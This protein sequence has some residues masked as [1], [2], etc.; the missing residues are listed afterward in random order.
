MADR[1]V[2][3]VLTAAV[4]GFTSAIGKAQSQV[5]TL[6]SSM[7]KASQTQSWSHV[8]TGLLAVGAT[9]TTIAGK[10]VS[11]AA[12]FDEAMSAVAATGDDAR[13]NIGQLRDLA[14]DM[15][16]RTKYSATEAAT[17]IEI[18]AKAGMSTADIISGGLSGALNLAASDNMS[19]EA[20]AEATA[21]TLTQF[22][23]AG[24]DAGHV[25]DLLAAGAGKAMG[26]VQDL[27]DALK[28][29]GLVA[30]NMGMSLEETVGTLSL[31]AQNG[32]VGA[33]AGT[34][35]KVMLQKLQNPSSTAKKAMD[36]LGIS[37]YD[38]SGKFIGM[39]S[40]AQQLQDKTAGLSQAQRDQAM[41]QIFGSHAIS[42]ATVLYKAGAQGVH[43]WTSAVNDQGFAEQMAAEKMNNLKGDLEQLSGAWETFMISAGSSAQGPLRA[44]MRGLTSI[45]DKL[46]E[47][48]QV[49][50]A[51]IMV[52]G[53]LGVSMV[54][55]GT[56]MKTVT[57]VAEFQAAMQSLTGFSSALD[58]AKAAAS[59]FVTAWKA[60][61]TSTKLATVAF[62]A[63]MIAAVELGK[64]LN[65]ATDHTG[66][67]KA[68]MGDLSSG[69]ISAS[70]ALARVSEA[71][72]KAY[73]SIGD[74][75]SGLAQAM[76]DAG[77]TG[78]GEKIADIAGNL[79]GLD[80]TTE[81]AQKNLQTLDEAMSSMVK[82]NPAAASQ[83][84][85]E[86]G[87]YIDEAG[88]SADETVSRF[89]GTA[90]A[91]RQEAAA[92]GVA[93]LSNQELADW[94]RT[95]VAPAAVQAGE[96]ATG[97]AD[98]NR[99]V[100]ASANDAGM[101]VAD[102]AS[103]VESLSKALNE[104]ADAAI[105]ASDA[106]I[107]VEAAI[108]DAAEAAATN[109]A[110]LDISTEAGRKNQSA[111]NDLA[112]SALKYRDAQ[113]QNSAGLEEINSATEH[114]R[115]NFVQIAQAMGM[116]AD[117]ANAMADAYGLTSMTVEQA[118]QSVKGTADN[119]EDMARK[120]GMA[121]D[122]AHGLRSA[123]E[124]EAESLDTAAQSALKHRDAMVQSQAS[125]ED[126]AKATQAARDSFISQAQA[127][128]M[129]EEQAKKLA[130]Q[131]GLMQ[132]NLDMSRQNIDN[133]TNSLRDN[134]AAAGL[135]SGAISDLA[136]KNQAGT[137]ALQAYAQQARDASAAQREGSMSAEEA[138]S[139]QQTARDSFIRT[140]TQMGI[141]E[142]Q[143]KKL[144]DAYG[145]IPGRITTDVSAPGAIDTRN[146]ALS[147]AA[148]VNSIP[149][150][151]STR[152]GTSADLSGYYAVQAALNSLQDRTVTITTLHR[153]VNSGGSTT[154]A[155][156][157]Y[158]T[159]P[160]TATSDSIPAW[161]SSGEFVMRAAAVSRYGLGLMRALNAG[162]V[163]ADRA[164]RYASGGPVGVDRSVRAARWTAQVAGGAGGAQTIVNVAPAVITE[165]QLDR[166]LTRAVE[167]VAS[168]VL[169]G[170]LRGV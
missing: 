37:A 59:G 18:L 142:D 87:H 19:L 7:Q 8:S 166:Y 151:H 169:A 46:S 38:A 61:P 94:M 84:F 105:S 62:S 118:G 32:I 11:M 109:G 4:S 29:G 91:L 162:A 9:L 132:L 86:L 121:A 5:E 2:R 138:A 165:G 33:E 131:Y 48:P 35:L 16:A 143:A 28:N 128:G 153:T 13:S 25:A 155:G 90:E 96:A 52:I 53:A 97:A 75:P 170:A 65:E 68:A 39:A 116:S 98:A 27:S 104:L 50:Q 20:A 111:L 49:G 85:S 161:L 95:G 74:A 154:L 134:A 139:A 73:M 71:A 24:S 160:G 58:T 43:E 69:S 152:I 12:N 63:A 3:V 55:L 22:G 123:H 157:G 64:A 110:N 100:A 145:L 23:L 47:Y 127:M 168:R 120:S 89:S 31:F 81:K 125:S 76:K 114:A 107:A 36:E 21:T 57:A 88:L 102:Y 136:S 164:P 167:Q 119:L 34:Q 60:V 163:A 112:E 93:G 40:I 82:G 146:Q 99:E 72:G 80:T 122:A 70:D 124:G 158:V 77:N 6:S 150:S 78:F 51:A 108:S 144:A 156:G 117:E 66:E 14:I 159:G 56:A 26:S 135:D 1:N 79:V 10:A 17:G 113:V 103:T 41:A 15:G 106:Q 147:V 141:N 148:A 137:V 83:V 30:S 92:A 115:E 101:N 44:M 149:G 42:A 130:D 133:A 54:A 140:A 126:I 67:V 45:V 129:S